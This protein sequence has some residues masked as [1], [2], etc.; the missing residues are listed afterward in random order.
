MFAVIRENMVNLR[1]SATAI[2]NEFDED[3]SGFLSYWEFTK[4]LERLGVKLSDSRMEMIM[5]DLDLDGSGQISLVEFENA[6][7]LNL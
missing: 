4:G 6:L 1:L 7:A 3:N 5:K 2:F